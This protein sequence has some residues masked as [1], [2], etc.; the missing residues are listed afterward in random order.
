MNKVKEYYERSVEED[1]LTKDKKHQT[2]YFITMEYINKYL[3]NGMKILEVGAGTGA[4]SITLAQEGYDVTAVELT[5]KNVGI[6]SAK[7]EEIPNIKIIQGNAINLSFLED[8]YFDMVLC[9]GPL[10][11]LDYQSRIKAML[12]CKRVCKQNG[13]MFFAYLSNNFAIMKCFEFFG[14]YI[15][16]PTILDSE[17][18]LHDDIFH[19]SDVREMDKISEMIDI[20]KVSVVATDGISELVK[21]NVNSFSEQEFEIWKKYLLKTCTNP[22]QLDYSEH[23]LYIARKRRKHV[24][25]AGACR[26]GKTTL[27]K[28]LSDLGFIHYKMD[29]VKRASYKVFELDKKSDWSV[30]SSKIVQIIESIIEDN[31]ADDSHER[32]VIDTPYIYPKDLANIDREK[33]VVIFV[34]YSQ[35][36][37]EEKLN[38]IRQNDSS[39]CWTNSVSDNEMI[40]QSEMSIEYSKI[41]KKQCEE[42][43]FV[44]FDTS[45]DFTETLEKAREYIEKNI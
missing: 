13:I 26:A 10:Y 24:I 7:S 14:N 33:F 41:V 15:G 40:K 42:N 25:V 16:N 17:F 1:R 9:F 31:A 27:S 4:Y 32:F 30:L 45:S 18:R 28:S 43:G 22:Y 35:T 20:H 44:Y 21:A 37:P 8:N 34:G 19:F 23:V 36:T 12:E 29:A 39:N 38:K 5:D 11:H 3:K 2:E 6:L